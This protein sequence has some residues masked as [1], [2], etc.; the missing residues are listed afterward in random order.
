ST[1]LGIAAAGSS[2]GV[3]RASRAGA[4]VSSGMLLGLSFPPFPFPVLSWVA[5]VP[6]IFLWDRHDS[7]RAVYLDSFAALIV[8]FAVAFQW[9]LFH[10]LPRTAAIS[11]PF[12][13][14][15]PLWMAAPFG[16]AHAV[17]VR[18]GRAAGLTAMVALYLVMEL[19]MRR[20]PFA[21]PWTLLGHTQAELFPVNRLASLGGVPALTLLILL[22]NIA[23]FMALKRRFVMAGSVGAL[24]LATFAIPR[25]AQTQGELDVALIQPGIPASAWSNSSDGSRARHL[26]ELSQA[27]AANSDFVIWPETALPHGADF[28]AVREWVDS[29]GTPLLSGA[30]LLEGNRYR[31]S[32]VLVAPEGDDAVYHKVRLVPFAEHVPFSEHVS[33]LERLSVPAGGVRGYLPGDS[34]RLFDL[35]RSRFGVMICFESLFDDVARS[36]RE[37]GAKFLVTITQDGWWGDSFGYRQHLAFNRLRAIE[38]G[39]P[40]LQVAVS[41]STALILPDGH[42]AAKSGWMERGAWIVSVG[43]GGTS[44]PFVRYGD[45][46]SLA[47]LSLVVLCSAVLASV[48]VA[49]RFERNPNRLAA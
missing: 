1:A 48:G 4:V 27:A 39:L 25:N 9:P 42:I 7:A 5:L 49:R 30:V 31:N 16:L 28:R 14:L 46:L 21:F 12:L 13:L 17:R 33:W 19:A 32:A 36:Y 41:G 29:I 45:V 34:L 10:L 20:G 24:L 3:S 15:L 11:A 43:A 8:M 37:R 35:D 38:T 6:L 22:T 26:I 23:V 44:T 40:L 18:L 47:A 2:I